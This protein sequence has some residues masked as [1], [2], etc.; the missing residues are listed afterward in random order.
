MKQDCFITN[1]KNLRT[2][3]QMSSETKEKRIE[4]DVYANICR[5]DGKII[6]ERKLTGIDDPTATFDE[7]EIKVF[8][9][10][11]ARS[12]VEIS[13]VYAETIDMNHEIAREWFEDEKER[14][15][16]DVL[17]HMHVK[18]I[19]FGLWAC[20]AIEYLRAKYEV[21]DCPDGKC[22]CTDEDHNVSQ[23]LP[24]SAFNKTTTAIF[25]TAQLLT[26]NYY[27]ARKEAESGKDLSKNEWKP[28]TR[29][30]RVEV[31]QTVKK[32]MGWMIPK[33]E[34]KDS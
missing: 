9:K 17:K 12:I 11:Y 32:R 13:D 27:L 10:M 25:D 22:I 21:H 15:T 23:D 7:R 5:K 29:V 4:L 26:K 6:C 8:S 16:A 33:S 14:K 20:E 1:H 34:Q 2:N 24:K 28:W 31:K 18:D 3:F 19:L 30:V